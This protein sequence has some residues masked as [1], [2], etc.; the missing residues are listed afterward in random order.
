MKILVADDHRLIVEDIA[1]ELKELFPDASI[2]GTNQ[3]NEIIPLEEKH[4]F[5]VI[6]IDID[7]DQLNGI[8]IA[9]KILE[10]KPRTNIIYVTSYEK[11]ALDSY[12]TRASAFLMKPVN[13]ERLKYAMEHLIYPVS[14]ITDEALRTVSVGS[15]ISAQITKYRELCGMSRSELASEMNCAVQTIH[16]WEKG[17]RL[18]DVPTLM[19]IAKILGVSLNEL[20]E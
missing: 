4:H 17:E 2:I 6:F 9:E 16:R 13:A 12:R 7:L 14:P 11:Y 18:P 5:D 19:K 3:P 20:T 8:D 10:K 15:G 1:D